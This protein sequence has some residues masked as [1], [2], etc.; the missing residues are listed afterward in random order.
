LSRTIATPI[1]TIGGT[2]AQVS[3]SGL[4]PGFVG[5]YQVNA[6]IPPN[7]PVGNAQVTIQAG[8]VFS[9]AATIAIQ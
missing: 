1:V 7:V 6:R 5:L 9:K 3:F 4:A 8:G 2:G